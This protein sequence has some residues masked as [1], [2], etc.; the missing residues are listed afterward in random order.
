MG[1]TACGLDFTARI[2]LL[3]IIIRIRRLSTRFYFLLHYKVEDE[4]K[5]QPACACVIVVI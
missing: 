1:D 5:A 4:K 3:T 2:I